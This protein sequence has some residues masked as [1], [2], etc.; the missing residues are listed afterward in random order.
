ML[1]PYLGNERLLFPEKDLVFCS[2]VSLLQTDQLFR[3]E[4]F[5]RDSKNKPICVF[6][7]MKVPPPIHSKH[8]SYLLK[9]KITHF[10]PL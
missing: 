9:S 6:G 5:E 3:S 10:K 2:S 4:G 1:M 8:K 7:F